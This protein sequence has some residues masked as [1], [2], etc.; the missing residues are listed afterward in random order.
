[1]TARW[2]SSIEAAESSIEAA[3]R[4]AREQ[5]SQKSRKDRDD[6]NTIAHDPAAGAN[7]LH[8]AV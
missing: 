4:R 3:F 2:E 1:M 6:R 5:A 7:A 8:T